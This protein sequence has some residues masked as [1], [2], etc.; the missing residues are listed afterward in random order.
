[1]AAYG[2][3]LP[4]PGWYTDP[5]SGALRY[6][7]GNRWGAYWAPQPW[8]GPAQGQWQQPWGA[9][10]PAS[11][12]A[13]VLSH[14]G[15]VLGGFLLPLIVYLVTDRSDH[16]TRAHAA[17]ALNFQ[18]TLLIASIAASVVVLVVAVVTLGLGL[19][20]IIPLFLA[21]AVLEIVWCIQGAIAASRWQPWRY[22]VC[23]RMVGA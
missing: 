12:T 3:Q 5:A 2:T 20:V 23:I 11:P 7:D 15:F 22:P 19:F 14:L 8:Q 18:L 6:W 4:P 17:E 13:A 16:F 1:M 9:P 21:G 10:A